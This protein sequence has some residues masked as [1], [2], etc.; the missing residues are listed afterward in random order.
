MKKIAIDI[1]EAVS[2][3]PAGKG[4][5]NLNITKELIKDKS[6]EWIL[7]SDQPTTI[8]K[9]VVV[10]DKKGIFW[11]L[12]AAAYIKSH[13]ISHYL[14]STSFITPLFLQDVPFSIVVHDLICFIYPKGHNL[15]ARLIERFAL[16]KL[17][18]KATNIFTVSN[19]TKKDLLT[20]FPHTDN[21]KVSV[22]NCGVDPDKFK[23]TKEKE[24]IILTVSTI[25]PRKNILGL[26]KAFNLIKDQVEHH[27]V[28][29]GGK[30]SG[31]KEVNKYIEEN[32]L[33]QRVHMQ[34]YV[35][36]LEELYAHAEL[37]VYP[38]FYE[39]FGI[40]IIEALSSGTKVACSERSSLPEAGGKH[41]FYFNPDDIDS[42]AETMIKAL[43]DKSKPKA[44]ID[45]ANAFS[46]RA[47]AAKI[48]KKL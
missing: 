39:G 45:W 19:N 14:S 31:A 47:A 24:K 43:N 18:R 9:N 37:F 23:P 22:T 32:N 20:H 44:G 2:L 36:D 16:P 29:V 25:I 48:L 11:H 13:N 41:A 35:K 33:S 4:I 15:K 46:W 34:G 28:I 27:L 42:I 7:I 40:P 3:N 21:F 17:L 38:S 6:V 26:V 1:R 12:Q 10:I 30:G 8:F 5:Y